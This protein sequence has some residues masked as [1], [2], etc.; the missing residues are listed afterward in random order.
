MCKVISLVDYGMLYSLEMYFD[1]IKSI[2]WMA[3]KEIAIFITSISMSN[4]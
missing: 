1:F 3:M 4:M 2:S